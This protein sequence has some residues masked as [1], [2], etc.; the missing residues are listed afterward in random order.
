MR[1]ATECCRVERYVGNSVGPPFDDN[2]IVAFAGSANGGP[3]GLHKFYLYSAFRVFENSQI[4]EHRKSN[5][6]CDAC[7][8]K[9][10]IRQCPLAPLPVVLQSEGPRV[11]RVQVELKLAIHQT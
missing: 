10:D 11:I 9:L 1:R 4:S 8:T 2:W 3:P 6:V 5:P 7:I